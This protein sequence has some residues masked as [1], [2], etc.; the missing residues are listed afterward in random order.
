ML[1]PLVEFMPIVVALVFMYNYE[2]VDPQKKPRTLRADD[3]FEYYDFIIVGAGSAGCVVA[4]R[5]SEEPQW[6]ILL[7][8]AGGDETA[9][10]DT[11]FL[12]LFLQTGETDW[13]YNTTIQT[14]AC[15]SV[16]GQC[17]YPRGKVL[18]GSSTTNGM[19][20]VR[21]N[22]YDFDNWAKM[23][24]KGWS[25]KDVLPYYKKLENYTVSDL[26]HLEHNIH[27]LIGPQSVQLAEFS[28][29]ITE[30]YLQ[31]TKEL[32][33]EVVDYNGHSQIGVGLTQSTT[34]QGSRASSAKSYLNPIRHRRNLH[35]V[36]NS[37]VVQLLFD[38]HHVGKPTK[39]VSGV[40][41]M[42]NGKKRVARATKEVI[43]SAG[44]VNTPKLLMLSGIGP[45]Q[46]LQ[47]LG[48]PVM[49]DLPVGNNFHDHVCVPIYIQVKKPIVIRDEEVFSKEA[50]INYT[51]H[52]SGPLSTSTFEALGFF[53]VFDYTS[54]VPNVEWHL[55]S[56]RM[57][58]AEEP[59]NIKPNVASTIVINLTPASVGTVRLRSANPKDDPLIDPNYFSEEI[60]IEILRKGILLNLEFFSTPTFSSLYP[61]FYTPA[62]RNC[63]HYISMK[64][65]FIDCLITQYSATIF[66]PVGSAKMGPKGDPTAVVSPEL[67]VHGFENLRVVD[68]SIMPKIT[69]GNTNGPT[70]MIGEKG[71]DLIKEKHLKEHFEYDYFGQPNFFSTYV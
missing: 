33:Y 45:K 71:A 13:N 6:N 69:R 40:V 37:E 35:V 15:Q 63:L 10:T 17:R 2:S 30:Y 4:H 49:A 44:S 66:H 21:G 19:A 41:F 61:E 67:I 23:G 26:F 56:F 64:E 55:N 20:Y 51:R 11:P 52:R 7:I 22:P 34:F 58:N 59:M 31:A 18:G 27:G 9:I 29:E 54:H 38:G 5:L 3:L 36:K 70:L 60:D 42:Q 25:Y 32:G 28:P 14:R 24:N 39:R 68:A 16:Q 47:S 57:V 53:N 65:A 62:Y 50:I 48:I 46:H 12:K 1:L 43:V 8:E